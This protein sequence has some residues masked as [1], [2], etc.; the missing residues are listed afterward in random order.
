MKRAAIVIAV[1]GMC[2]WSL[3]QSDSKPASQNPP[4]GQAAQP[5]GQA[6]A[7]QGKRPP[8]AKTQPEFDAYKAAAAQT[9]PAA[10]GKSCGRLRDEVS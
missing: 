10:R 9:D 2:T 3:G 7:P 1:L 8:A 6:A 5:A 4:A